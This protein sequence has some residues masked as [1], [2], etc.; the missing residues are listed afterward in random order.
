MSVT[1][2][3]ACLQITANDRRR[4]HLKTSVRPFAWDVPGR[5]LG[6]TNTKE[7]NANLFVPCREFSQADMGQ[8]TARLDEMTWC[9]TISQRLST[10]VKITC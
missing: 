7:S 6:H 5:L 9:L 2:A 4:P 3:V 1:G 10:V 8:Q